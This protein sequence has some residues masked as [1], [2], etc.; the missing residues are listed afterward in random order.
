[1]ARVLLP[2]MR[3]GFAGSLRQFA[4][5]AEEHRVAEERRRS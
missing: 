5:V 3:V 1:V 2:L 4:V